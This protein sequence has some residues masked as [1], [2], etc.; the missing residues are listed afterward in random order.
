MQLGL[1]RRHTFGRYLTCIGDQSHRTVPAVFRAVSI[2]F[3]NFHSIARCGLS[4]IPRSS[5]EAKLVNAKANIRRHRIC[6]LFNNQQL[7]CWPATRHASN[8]PLNVRV[9]LCILSFSLL[10]NL[11]LIT[12]VSFS[13]I[14][15]FYTSAR[16]LHSD[17]LLVNEII[18]WTIKR[19]SIEQ[20]Y[21]F[22][23]QTWVTLIYSVMMEWRVLF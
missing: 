1:H 19:W 12:R 8:F 23:E 22:D 15:S 16:I 5:V 11:S 2:Y 7:Q 4:V 20:K 10:R 21:R 13:A 18:K 9:L 14:S 3:F 6:A 17:A